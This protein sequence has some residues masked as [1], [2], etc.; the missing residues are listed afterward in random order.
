[1]PVDTYTGHVCV[2]SCRHRYWTR[3]STCSQRVIVIMLSRPISRPSLCITGHRRHSLTAAVD[4]ALCWGSNYAR[5]RTGAT[6]PSESAHSRPVL[7]P[8][9]P[10]MHSSLHC[11]S[12]LMVLEHC[13][14]LVLARLHIALEGGAD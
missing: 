13:S 12:I 8:T 14:V 2:S 10:A 1:M 9:Q 5:R 4:R 7:L 6:P 3:C 11:V